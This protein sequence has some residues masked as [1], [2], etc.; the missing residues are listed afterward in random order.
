M[1]YNERIPYLH[2]ST[3]STQPQY[4]MGLK[5]TSTRLKDGELIIT[6]TCLTVVL[7]DFVN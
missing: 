3:I 2:R 7:E 1:N 5:S 4:T 6:F